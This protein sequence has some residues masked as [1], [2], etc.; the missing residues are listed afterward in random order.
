MLL[1]EVQELL[2]LEQ[3]GL[4]ND[5][6]VCLGPAQHEHLLEQELTH[7]HTHAH[8]HTYIAGWSVE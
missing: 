2:V 4:L 5:L 6:D 3:A 7:L 1:Q 8:K